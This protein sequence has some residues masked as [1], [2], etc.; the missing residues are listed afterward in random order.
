MGSACICS[1]TQVNLSSCRPI[2]T[3]K[4]SSCTSIS[5]NQ[6]STEPWAKAVE[7]Y[8]STSDPIKSFSIHNPKK[9]KN[10]L[11]SGPPPQFRWSAWKS[12]LNYSPLSIPKQEISEYFLNLIEQD[13]PRTFPFNSFFQD[14]EN[15]KALKEVLINVVRLDPALGYTQG[16]NFLAGVFLLVSKNNVFESSVMMHIF[17]NNFEGKGLFEPGFPKLSELTNKF[18]SGFNKKLPNLFEWFQDI[19][20]DNNLWLTKWFMTLFAYSFDIE[21]VIR[22]WDLIFI[23]GLESM[24]NLTLAVLCTLKKTLMNKG[25]LETLDLL[26]AVDSSKIDFE[27]VIAISKIGQKSKTHK[28]S[29]F[30][31]TEISDGLSD[32]DVEIQLESSKNRRFSFGVGFGK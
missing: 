10:L 14:N 8:S 25:L 3:Q 26:K 27:A 7:I 1:K 23:Y 22:F 5:S 24:V 20:M 19:Q 28:D 4:S 16:M 21:I 30:K 17:L 18:S 6:V 32:S 12:A 31:E 13:V 2:H 29:I 11:I 15:L 9:F